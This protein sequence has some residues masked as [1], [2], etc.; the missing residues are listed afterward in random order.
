MN[1]Q[2]VMQLINQMMNPQQVLQK[3]EIPQECMRSPQSVE[4]YLLNT[5]KI[6][7]QQ[8]EQ[9]KQFYQQI[10]QYYQQLFRR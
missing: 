6:N 2:N 4:Q 1:I 8:V 3:L 5:G 7:Q 10:K 9:A